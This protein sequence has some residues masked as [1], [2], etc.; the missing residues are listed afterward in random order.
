MKPVITGAAGTISKSFRKCRS[1]IPGKHEIKELQATAIPGTVRILRG[2]L[3]LKYRTFIEA[4]NGI[5]ATNCN[6][7]TVQPRN[8]VHVIINNNNNNNEFI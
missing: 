1:S 2:V 8:M 7:N 3:M 6:C 4:N 5:C